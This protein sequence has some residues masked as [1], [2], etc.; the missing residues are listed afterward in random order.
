MHYVDPAY[1]HCMHSLEFSGDLT[2]D[3]FESEI[4]GMRAQ[5]KRIREPGKENAVAM[6]LYV[7]KR[8]LFPH[9]IHFSCIDCIFFFV[10]NDN[11]HCVWLALWSHNVSPKHLIT[12]RSNQSVGMVLGTPAPKYIAQDATYERAAMP[13]VRS[14]HLPVPVTAKLLRNS[15]F[16]FWGAATAKKKRKTEKFCFPPWPLALSFREDYAESMHT[17]THTAWTLTHTQY[18]HS[19]ASDCLSWSMCCYCT[20]FFFLSLLLACNLTDFT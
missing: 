15:A 10:L 18:F 11:K 4:T 17:H 12:S 14:N 3:L 6:L 9:R 5:R 16:L 19:I 1:I 7:L 2:T 8:T 13:Q 20:V